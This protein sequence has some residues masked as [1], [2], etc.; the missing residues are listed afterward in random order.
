MQTDFLRDY[1]YIACMSDQLKQVPIA[2]QIL[3]EHLVLFRDKDGHAGVL[4]DRCPHRNLALSRGSVTGNGLQCAYHGWT[5][6]RDGLCTLIPAQCEPSK[7]EIRMQSFPVQES[8]GFVWVYMGKQ[9]GQSRRAESKQSNQGAPLQFPLYNEPRARHWVMERVFEGN[10]LYCAENFLDVP[11]TIFVHAGI[12]RN[13]SGKELDYE[14]TAGKDW[15]QAEFFD[16]GAFDTFLGRLLIP[17]ETRM[18]HTDRF[19]LPATTRVDYYFNES[20]NFIVMSQ[21]TPITHTKTR[22]FTYMAFRFDP[23]AWWI[24]KIYEP[25][26]NRILDQD[27]IVIKEQRDD[28]GRFTSPSFQFH[29]TDAIGREIFQLVNGKK[30][31]ARIRRGRMRV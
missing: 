13:E 20:R 6:D 12:F 17:R 23:I 14:V 21:C 31:P 18:V 3:G 25:L 7:K 9:T 28:I 1:W 24:Q 22:V 19:I 4:L 10:A 8:Q 30:L 29:S 27:V 15:V 5:Y 16:E 11:H 2:R 26:S